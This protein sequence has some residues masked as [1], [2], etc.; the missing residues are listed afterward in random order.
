VTVSVDWALSDHENRLE[1]ESTRT[2]AHE[3]LIGEC[4]ILSRALLRA[5]ES[6]EWRAD[7]GADRQFIGDV[8]CHIHCHL[9]L[10]AR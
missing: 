6:N 5:G 8:A 10:A 4:N 9:G 2:M 7:L 3:V 1:L